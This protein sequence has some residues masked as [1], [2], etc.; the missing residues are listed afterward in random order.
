MVTLFDF[1]SAVLIG[2]N[3]SY[4]RRSRSDLKENERDTSFYIKRESYSHYNSEKY[5]ILIPFYCGIVLT[6]LAPIS[7][8]G[9]TYSNNS[10]AICRRI[11]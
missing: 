6:L 8:N 2:G 7:Q 4:L 9:Q 11:I 5:H 10:L 3:A 1:L